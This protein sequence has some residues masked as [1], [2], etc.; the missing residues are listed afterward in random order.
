[1]SCSWDWNQEEDSS[2]VLPSHKDSNSKCRTHPSIQNYER[3]IIKKSNPGSV[4]WNAQSCDWESVF[5]TTL[6]TARNLQEVFPGPIA[7][8]LFGKTWRRWGNTESIK[9]WF[10]RLRT[11]PF[12]YSARHPVNK[13]FIQ[14][15]AWTNTGNIIT[16]HKKRSLHSASLIQYFIKLTLIRPLV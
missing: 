11:F 4:F 8:Q 6:L 16:S 7:G 10:T 1:M 9:C 13:T 2:S 5:H 3:L 15:W 12:H 14:L